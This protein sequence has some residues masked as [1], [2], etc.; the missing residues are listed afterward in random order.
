MLLVG[1]R[2]PRL[3]WKVLEWDCCPPF[4]R[5]L[6]LDRPDRLVWPPEVQQVPVVVAVLV[7]HGSVLEPVADLLE[8]LPEQVG[9]PGEEQLPALAVGRLVVVGLLVVPQSEVVELLLAVDV[10]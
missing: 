9:V 2:V 4:W 10:T 5:V 3:L 6:K 1:L 7:L 8:Q